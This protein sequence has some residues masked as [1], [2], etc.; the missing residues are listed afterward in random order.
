MITINL[1]YALPFYILAYAIYAEAPRNTS[2]QRLGWWL[3]L[4]LL[5]S[6]GSRIAE[7]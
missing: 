1:L 3:L 6:L 5:V 4:G 2:W 7:G